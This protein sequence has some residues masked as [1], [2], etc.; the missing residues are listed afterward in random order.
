MGVHIAFCMHI[1]VLGSSLTGTLPI[2][3]L[4]VIGIINLL[5]RLRDPVGFSS[6]MY[7]CRGDHGWFI[8][9]CGSE[10]LPFCPRYRMILGC[11]GG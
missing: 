4:F 8:F 11:V 3:F 10:I 7:Y 9:R 6:C 1:N 2:Y 5:I